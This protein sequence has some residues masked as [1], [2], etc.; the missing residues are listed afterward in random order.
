MDPATLHP[1]RR[2][3]PHGVFQVDLVPRRTEHLAGPCS[4]QNR[5]LNRQCPYRLTLA[6]PEQEVGHSLIWQGRMVPLPAF[7]TA[8]Q[9]LVEMPAPEG[10]IWAVAMSFGSGSVE[11][12]LYAASKA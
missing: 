3:G 2:D 12:M 4:G 11:Y 10:R 1:C 6:H 8:G 7:G 9:Q 5:E